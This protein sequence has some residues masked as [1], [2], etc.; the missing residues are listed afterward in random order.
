MCI[1]VLGIIL[2]AVSLFSSCSKEN[3]LI[4]AVKKEDYKTA[5]NLI[6]RGCNPNLEYDGYPILWHALEKGND[7]LI[8]TLIEYGAD[9]NWQ[10]EKN[11]TSIF[12]KSIE[13]RN[14]RSIKLLLENNVDLRYRDSH[15]S[16]IFADILFRDD[17]NL[18]KFFLS[19]E[20]C[21]TYCLNDE[22]TLYALALYWHKY[23]P[24]IYDIIYGDGYQIPDEI[25]VLLLSI[26][27]ID[28]L[29]FFISKGVDVNKKYYDE[30]ADEWYTPLQ[31]AYEYKSNLMPRNDFTEYE[32]WEEDLA[33]ADEV[34]KYL[35]QVINE[36]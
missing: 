35:K 25:P 28:A 4:E 27:N 21:C 3:D 9:V 29:K 7:Q 23:N 18:V 1:N 14:Y 12:F 13:E 10:N 36:R 22:Q 30:E 33:K 24:E 11:T 17:Y 19:F 26:S 32:G 5:V 34:I 8:E 20:K 6:K 2:F 31:M 16:G 15:N